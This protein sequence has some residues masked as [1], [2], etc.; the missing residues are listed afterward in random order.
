MGR[1]VDSTGPVSAGPGT[2]GVSERSSD[3]T[4]V[5]I[6]TAATKTTIPTT[7]AAMRWFR[8]CGPA[9]GCVAL[10]PRRAP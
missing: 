6:Q 9:A 3:P 2:A 5:T 7:P 10:A 1:R 4:L 8:A